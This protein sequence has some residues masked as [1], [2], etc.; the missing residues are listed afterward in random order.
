M[1]T[2]TAAQR[3]DDTSEVRR[4][5]WSKA[6]WLMVGA[7]CVVAV[8]LPAIVAVVAGSFD[9]PQNDDWAYRRVAEH[10]AQT[11]HLVFT[12]WSVMTLVGQILWS[13]PFLRVFGDHTWVFGTST[14]V[15]GVVGVFSAYYIARRLL[16]P[17]WAA[18][19]VL[20]VALVPGFGWSTSTFMTDVPTFA[21]EMACLALGV[22]ALGRHG[23]SR[24]AFLWASMAVGL[25][26]FSIR[27]FALAAPV[28]VLFCA[29][30]G[31]S[32]RRRSRYL[33]VGVV[34][35]V[36]SGVVYAWGT[37]IPGALHQT[38]ALPS[39]A[40]VARTAREYY[41]LA[42]LLS[43]AVA[44][45]AWRRLRWRLSVATVT[46][47]VVFFLGVAVGRHGS[48]LAGNYL[49]AHG[50]GSNAIL[51]GGRATPLPAP[52]WDLFK[53]IALVSGGLLAGVA[54]TVN[55]QSVRRW[56]SWTPGTPIGVVWVF[57][58]LFAAGL[59]V[60]GL[61]A[62]ANIFDRYLWPLV[63][64]LAVLLFSYSQPAPRRE[65][66]RPVVGV[67]VG[68]SVMLVLVTA[69]LTVN[70][71][72]YNAARWNAG[73]VAVSHGVPAKAVDAGFEWVGGHA[74][75]MVDKA[76][77]PAAAPVYE[78][79]YGRMEPGFREC[80]VVSGSPLDYPD[81]HLVKTTSYELLGFVG[82]RNL[83]VYVSSAPGC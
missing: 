2:M 8:L 4:A 53:V 14:A 27:E 81:L 67:V 3:T 78:P 42:F 65:W 19:S 13:W 73:Q 25:F 38:L 22:A 33:A 80:A 20:L 37:H 55:G 16:A 62:T 40:S 31:D 51:L 59:A 36:V 46:A 74:T 68:L 17:G 5:V 83:Y 49:D 56:R 30:A 48:V 82:S 77:D 45:A 35:L 1:S 60:F 44:V 79:W 7:L 58:A 28:A 26:G 70:A 71:D 29:G 52:L 6:D 18:A 12:G 24:W 57:A 10:F 23:W 66:P 64:A 9:I 32:P 76:L 61:L 21:A 72:T 41:T 75:T 39:G 69:A 43:P 63:F 47:V 50:I 34:V 15:L 54:L 11:G